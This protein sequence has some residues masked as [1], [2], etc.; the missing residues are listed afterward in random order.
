MQKHNAEEAEAARAQSIFD[1]TWTS[2]ALESILLRNVCVR[3]GP[4]IVGLADQAVARAAQLLGIGRGMDSLAAAFS[5]RRC[6]SP[7]K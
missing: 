1:D 7:A 6:V 3:H 2:A 5:P 4:F